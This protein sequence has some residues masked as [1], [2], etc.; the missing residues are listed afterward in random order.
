MFRYEAPQAGRMRQFHQCGVELLGAAGPEADA[1]VLALA[2]DFLT[3][4]DLNATLHL[5]TL[6]TAAG[7]VEFLRQLK[8]YL[9]PYRARLSEDSQHRLDVNPLRIFDSKDAGDRALLIGAPSLLEHIKANDADSLH[10][11][12]R[13]CSYLDA[14]GVAYEVDP[15]LVRGFDYY[16]RTAFEFVSDALGAQSTVLAGGRYDGL[17][18]ELG[19]AATPG[20]GFAPGIERL[21]LARQAT[22]PA[23]PECTYCTACAPAAFAATAISSAAA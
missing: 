2:A 12:E 22:P 17:I 9:E 8:A 3:A 16:S 18:E 21:I 13:V 4:L 11:F 1:E 15:Q 5:N 19:G 6:G 20:I 14:L 7:R 23:L 10:H